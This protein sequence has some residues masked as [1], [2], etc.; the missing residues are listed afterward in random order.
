LDT[1]VLQAGDDFIVPEISLEK[2]VGAIRIDTDP[3][4]AMVWLNGSEYETKTPCAIEGLWI[5][6]R[7][8]IRLALAEYDPVSVPLVQVAEGAVLVLK[9]TLSPSTQSVWI[10]TIPDSASVFIDEELISDYRSQ[11]VSLRYG[12]RAITAELFGY[13]TT[14]HHIKIPLD[15]NTLRIELQR[16]PDGYLQ[17]SI[18]EGFGDVF[19][20]N[21]LAK[22]GTNHYPLTPLRV[23]KHRV[24]VKREGYVSY[25]RLI[26]ISSNDTIILSVFMTEQAE[27]ARH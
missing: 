18:R 17:I 19:I 23:G 1:L 5:E 9:R 14:T 13:K 3:E 12:K 20:D 11:P 7:Y 16:L 4:G 24:L 21:K 15:Q 26:T 27:G 22:S 10:R 2:R 8:D 25:D 6:K